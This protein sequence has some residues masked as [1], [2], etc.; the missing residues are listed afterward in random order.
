MTYQ[1]SKI[2]LP[3]LAAAALLAAGLTGQAAAETQA[4]GPRL[5]L[6]QSGKDQQIKPVIR[7]L[8]K[9]PTKP[10]RGGG[11][12]QGPGSI[13]SKPPAALPDFILEPGLPG[14]VSLGLPNAG[15]CKRKG[16]AGGPA[17]T[18]ALKVKFATN[19]TQAPD[20]GWGASQVT[21]AF[22]GAGMVSLPLPSPSWNGTV[23]LET[24]IPNGCYNIGG[25]QFT[26]KVDPTNV[27][28][29]TSNANNNKT[30]FCAA[31]AG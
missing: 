29:E 27:V 1:T 7:R 21:I 26:I 23:A 18:I 9:K 4:Q 30:T 6:A 28:P 25:C 19:G 5:L 17:D 22:N 31:P 3:A 13:G 11:V 14:N 2:A 16:N 24:P 20:N 12:P 15:Y 10:S 8:Q